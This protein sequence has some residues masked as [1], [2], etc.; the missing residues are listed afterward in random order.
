MRSLLVRPTCTVCVFVS[1]SGCVCVCVCVCVCACVCVCVC[2]WRCVCVC[3]TLS[4]L[5]ACRD[6]GLELLH[7]LLCSVGSQMGRGESFNRSA[8]EAACVCVCGDRE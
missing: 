1:V 7:K 5:G 6:G 3:V 4:L 2:V 8:V